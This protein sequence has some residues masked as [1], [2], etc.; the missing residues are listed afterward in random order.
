MTFRNILVTASFSKVGDEAESELDGKSSAVAGLV[1]HFPPCTFLESINNA[2]LSLSPCFFAAHAI[3][4][5]KK[6]KKKKNQPPSL[7]P[8]FCIALVSAASTFVF[9][10]LSSAI[11]HGTPLASELLIDYSSFLIL[12]RVTHI[13]NFILHQSF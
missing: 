13:S 5:Q 3:C 11:H 8:S 9:S 10:V 7:H 2:I 1:I 12:F 4:Y 6:K